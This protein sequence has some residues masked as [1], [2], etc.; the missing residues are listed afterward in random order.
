VSA[1]LVE[2][3]KKGREPPH[4]LIGLV[5]HGDWRHIAVEIGE[6]AAS[7]NAPHIIDVTVLDPVRPRNKL[8]ARLLAIPPFYA[9]ALTPQSQGID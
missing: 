7:I 8:Q 6:V 5:A 9:R 3:V 4:L 1:H 2:T